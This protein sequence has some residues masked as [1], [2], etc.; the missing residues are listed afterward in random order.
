MEEN[1]KIVLTGATGWLGQNIMYT[2]QK[3]IPSEVFNK[4]VIAFA[5]TE[6]YIFSS[7]YEYNK[8]IKIPIYPLKEIS[9]ILKFK[10]IDLIHTAFLTPDKIGEVSSNEFINQNKEINSITKELIGEHPECKV[11]YFSSGITK[12]NT[13]KSNKSKI[14]YSLLKKE[15]ENYFRNS[16][17]PK[18]NLRVYAL[19][20]KFITKPEKYALSNFILEAK[21]SKIIKLKKSRNVIRGYCSAEDLAKLSYSWIKSKDKGYDYPIEAISY[22]SNLENIAKTVSKL[23]KA[24][25]LYTNSNKKEIKDYYYDDPKKYINL[26]KKFNVKKKKFNDQILETSLSINK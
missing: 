11:V 16:K 15:E 3:N 9:K 6:K 7:A 25:I 14:L 17:N 13:Y 12:V 18:L 20:G 23:F 19:S 1:K 26:L 22:I 4:N 24:K 8:R 5:K 21:I 2:L 10:K